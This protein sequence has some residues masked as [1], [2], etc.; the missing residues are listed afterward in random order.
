MIA[1]LKQKN[2]PA[3]SEF[4]FGDDLPKRILNVTVNKKVLS[5]SKTS[6]QSLNSFFKS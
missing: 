5:T 2:V 6:F 1:F 3:N 4:L